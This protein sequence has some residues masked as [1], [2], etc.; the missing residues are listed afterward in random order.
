MHNARHEGPSSVGGAAPEGAAPAGPMLL[1]PCGDALRA[2]YEAVGTLLQLLQT[3][4]A[5]PGDVLEVAE[6]IGALVTKVN[7]AHTL[8]IGQAKDSGMWAVT[9]FASSTAWLRSTHLMD[10]SRARA[11]ERT[12]S[13]LDHN[14]RTRTAFVEGRVSAEHVAAI[15]RVTAS[16][17]RRATAYPIFEEALLQVAA[18]STPRRTARVL[19]AWADALDSS[20]ANDESKNEYERRSLHLSPVA[21]GWDLRGWLPN[22]IGA[23]LAGLLNEVMEQRRRDSDDDAVDPPSARRLDALM[24]LARAAAATGRPDG[25]GPFLSNG[26][27]HRARVVVTVPLQRLTQDRGNSSSGHGRAGYGANDF[28]SSGQGADPTECAGSWECH[29]GPGEG[30]LSMNEVL[31][32]SCDAEI[33]RLILGPQSQ[34]LDIGRSSRV[35]PE[36]IRTALHRRDGGCVMPGCRRPPGWCEAHH[37]EHWSAGGTTAVQ[38]LALIC[39]RHHHELHNGTWQITM[40]DG[41]PDVRRRSRR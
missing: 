12:A 38:N 24:D 31:R 1:G 19:R 5:P 36:H 10:S 40:V 17:P 33:Q 29:N 39:S 22:A 6:Q 26:A 25:L 3:E 21:D 16:C 32:L 9:G 14:L 35:V 4:P 11:L 7:A 30:F 20:S 34:P 15:R 41:V 37:V 27:R 18:N 8:A 2:A 28:L 13:W 23:E